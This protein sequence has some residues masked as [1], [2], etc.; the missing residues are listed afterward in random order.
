MLSRAF[1]FAGVCGVLCFRGIEEFRGVTGPANG[2]DDRLRTGLD[3]RRPAHGG[4]V[5]LEG[6]HCAG[7]AP[8]LP[9]GLR[10]VPGAPAASHAVDGQFRSGPA[11]VLCGCRLV[12]LDGF[13]SGIVEVFSRIKTVPSSIV[14]N[15]AP[16]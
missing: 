9:D 14:R 3:V 11:G 15:Q 13:Q 8:N 12:S 5:F 2:L 7:D 4:G 10:D 1:L 16:K 6:D